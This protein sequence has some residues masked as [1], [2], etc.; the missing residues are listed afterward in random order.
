MPGAGTEAFVRL[1]VEPPVE[2]RWPT[3]VQ[4]LAVVSNPNVGYPPYGM[5]TLSRPDGGYMSDHYDSGGHAYHVIKNGFLITV[6]SL[7]SKFFAQLIRDGRAEYVWAPH[8]PL[9]WQPTLPA[10]APRTNED[11]RYTYKRHHEFPDVDV[12]PIRA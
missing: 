12:A 2:I 1:L 6:P 10:S 3:F 9:A 8:T 7:H 4:I 5:V 11:A